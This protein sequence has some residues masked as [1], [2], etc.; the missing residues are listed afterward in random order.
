MDIP[1]YDLTTDE[2]LQVALERLPPFKRG[3]ITDVALRKIL[4]HLL[5]YRRRKMLDDIL[6]RI[7]SYLPGASPAYDAK[8]LVCSLDPRRSLS[9][10]KR[11]FRA[12]PAVSL[13]NLIKF[14]HVNYA[15]KLACEH[16]LSPISRLGNDILEL[17]L[18]RLNPQLKDLIKPW[19]RA[20]L[21]VES[22][23][24]IPPPPQF[25]K[26]S[27]DFNHF[28]WTSSRTSFYSSLTH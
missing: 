13:E 19:D 2:D 5:P 16:K 4:K 14:A 17:V 28:V 1:L 10:P 24:S 3:K 20:S 6:C 26:D 11:L 25:V 18:D 27:A 7:L 22:F 15:V 23:V 21:S 12:C 9:I 8:V